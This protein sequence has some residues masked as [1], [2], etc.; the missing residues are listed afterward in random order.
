MKHDEMITVIQAHKE[1]KQIQVQLGNGTWFDTL[2]VFD[3]SRYTYRIKPEPEPNIIQF[4][5]I[6]PCGNNCGFSS[7]KGSQD[8]V[9]VTF[10][11]DTLQ[12]ESV[13]IIK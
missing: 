8:N 7:Y 4:G 9:C 1:G 2:C 13:E 12:P 11:G 10:N 5:R 3:F 6:H